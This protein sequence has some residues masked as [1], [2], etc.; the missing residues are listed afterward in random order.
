MA[1]NGFHKCFDDLYKRWQKKG[2]C[3]YFFLLIE[4][5]IERESSVGRGQFESGVVLT[6]GAA[7]ASQAV[8]SGKVFQQLLLLLLGGGGG[9]RGRRVV[10]QLLRA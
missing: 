3:P 7:A 8:A 9:R 6:V 4:D 1:K 5:I 2:R 10:A